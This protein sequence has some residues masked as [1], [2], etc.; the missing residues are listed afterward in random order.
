MFGGV[1]YSSLRFLVPLSTRGNIPGTRDLGGF[2]LPLAYI[3]AI[4][5]LHTIDE[6]FSILSPKSPTGYSGGQANN[7]SCPL[8]TSGDSVDG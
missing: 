5:T 6:A 1:D 7:L 3:V 8:G 2:S 4:L